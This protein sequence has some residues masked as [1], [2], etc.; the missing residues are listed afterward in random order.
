MKRREDILCRYDVG[1]L[2][3]FYILLFAVTNFIRLLPV[4]GQRYLYT[5]QIMSIYMFFKVL[6]PQKAKYFYFL[7]GSWA[8]YIFLRWFYS[9]AGNSLVPKNVYYDNLFYLIQEYL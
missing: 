2:Y 5:V 3:P 4:I 8:L 9:G 7:L 1:R 6:Y